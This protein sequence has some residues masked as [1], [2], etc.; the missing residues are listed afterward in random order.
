M[1][2]QRAL[3]LFRG[4]QKLMDNTTSPVR[5]EDGKSNNLILYM[6]P[7]RIMPKTTPEYPYL[8]PAQ[9]PPP[10]SNLTIALVLTLPSQDQ[11]V[12]CPKNAPVSHKKVPESC[13]VSNNEFF[14]F[15]K[16]NVSNQIKY[17]YF[18]LINLSYGYNK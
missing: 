5:K 8:H 18:P 14:F 6:L 2:G 15:V 13:D 4:E 1:G 16:W 10:P 12:G 11:H 9:L 7:E 17:D 3:C